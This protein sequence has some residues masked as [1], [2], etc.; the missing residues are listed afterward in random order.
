MML[1]DMG[2][3]RVVIVTGAGGIGCGRAIASRFAAGGASV[4]VSD[5]SAD[6]GRETAR[7]IESRGGRAR[8]RAA[9]V[10]R[11]P[12][13]R[14]L[15]AFAETTYGALDVLVNNASAPHG[16]SDDLDDWSDAIET[17]LLGAIHATRWAI[18][19]MRRQARGGAIS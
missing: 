16:S 3:T 2:D 18:D 15:V 14:E 10:R 6:G 8:F 19:A 1:R 11:E 4:V 13:V 5:V 7:L 9:D 17:D 12:D